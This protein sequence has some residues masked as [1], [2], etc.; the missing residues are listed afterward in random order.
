MW[1]KYRS[2]QWHTKKLFI[3]K[4]RKT[5]RAKCILYTRRVIPWRCRGS[6]ARSFG[7]V[8]ESYDYS[9]D[10]CK[11]QARLL[12]MWWLLCLRCLGGV[13]GGIGVVLWFVGV[14]CSVV[15]F[16]VGGGVCCLLWWCW[17][18]WVGFFFVCYLWCNGLCLCGEVVGWW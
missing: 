10:N 12:L 7:A 6:T 11:R 14:L 17:L 5:I 15:L 3:T 16:M 4:Y 8:S 9:E 13:G 1:W 2:I 18:G